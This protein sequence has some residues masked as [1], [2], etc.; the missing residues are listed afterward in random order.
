MMRFTVTQQKDFL[1]L[2]RECVLQH[3]FISGYWINKGQ[4]KC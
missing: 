3:G 2:F 4:T 1:V